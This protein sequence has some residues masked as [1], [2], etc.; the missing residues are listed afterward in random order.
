MAMKTDIL[1][2]VQLTDLHDIVREAGQIGL[3]YFGKNIKNWQKPDDTPITEADLAV[4]DFLDARLKALMPKFGW[5][6]EETVDNLERQNCE[7]I[8]VVDPIDG[9]KAFIKG[10]A[11]WVVSV[12]IVKDNRPILGLIYDPIAQILYFAQH[13]HGA[14]IINE[15]K[16]RVKIQPSDR[17]NVHEANILAYKF[18]FDRMTTRS[19]YIWPNM[20]YQIVNSMAMRVA[21]VA[22][23]EFD[24][25]VSFTIKG[26]WDIAAADIII[27][28]AGGM[29]TDGLG[30]M[31]VYNKAEPSLP[32]MVA[33][34]AKLHPNIIE[35]TANFNF[36]IDNIFNQ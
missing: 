28:E 2:Q 29:I 35:H 17:D 14:Y 23:G 7:Y 3:S 6:S 31:L 13:G 32:H 34:G 15:E 8:W 27:H 18:H 9:T 4:N 25:M 5:L 21:L 36:P 26:E 22:C 33:A 19:N 10:L 1:S 16:Q 20:Q 11:E 30:Q 24:A 12:A